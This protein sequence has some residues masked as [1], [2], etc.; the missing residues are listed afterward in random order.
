MRPSENWIVSDDFLPQGIVSGAVQIKKYLCSL[1]S[2]QETAIVA[3]YKMSQF[4]IMKKIHLITLKLL[5]LTV[6]LVF[7]T[8]YIHMRDVC[9]DFDCTQPFCATIQSR[10]SKCP[11]AL[12]KSFI[13]LSDMKMLFMSFLHRWEGTSNCGF[14]CPEVLKALV[15]R[16]GI[17]KCSLVKIRSKL[18]EASLG[19][20]L[21]TLQK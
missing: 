1:Y 4:Y 18:S 16:Q 13:S 20:N 9:T 14:L 11:T 7:I 6:V 21:T 19:R 12:G 5:L 2:C 10:I 3:R 17:Y 8:C 15:K